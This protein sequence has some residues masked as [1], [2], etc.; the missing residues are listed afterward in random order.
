MNSEIDHLITTSGSSSGPEHKPGQLSL[1]EAI[2][3]LPF[4][5]GMIFGP[6]CPICRPE[7]GGLVGQAFRCLPHRPLPRPL[8]SGLA[9]SFAALMALRWFVSDS[10]LLSKGDFPATLHF[11]DED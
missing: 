2:C 3:T 7:G 4:L 11:T 6:S 8:P 10:H 1:L 9:L 5:L